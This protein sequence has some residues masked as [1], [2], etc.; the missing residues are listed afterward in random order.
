[1][2]QSINFCQFTD[3]FKW[4]RPDNFSYNGL[5]ALFDYLEE[6]E[7]STGEELELD[8][9]GLCC[10]FSEYRDEKEAVEAYG[11]EYST[12]DDLRENTTVIDIKGGGY[13][14]QDF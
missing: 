11:E 10:D 9:I 6:F 3:Q 12:I 14:I 5:R 2:K 1:M 4:L 7:D 8:V 13:I